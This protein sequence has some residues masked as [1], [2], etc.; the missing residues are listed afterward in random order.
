MSTQAPVRKR[1]SALRAQPCR[2][3]AGEEST[4]EESARGESMP[5][6]TARAERD[7]HWTAIRPMRRRQTV[8][9][10]P[11]ADDGDTLV[12]FQAVTN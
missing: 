2:L 9:R 11:A 10:R 1:K 3:A 5:N 6:N 8:S 12:G 7:S 4:D